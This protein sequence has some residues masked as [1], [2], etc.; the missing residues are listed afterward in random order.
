MSFQNH[1]AHPFTPFANLG[2]NRLLKMWI[3]LRLRRDGME[4]EQGRWCRIYRR[5]EYCYTEY[6]EDNN[7]FWPQ[8]NYR[9]FATVVLPSSRPTVQSRSRWC[10][11]T[12][13]ACWFNG[14]RLGYLEGMLCDRSQCARWQSVG[15]L[16]NCESLRVRI[17][18][19]PDAENVNIL[20]GLCLAEL[21]EEVRCIG[22]I[23]V[24]HS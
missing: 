19:R 10:P 4:T 21:E 20:E 11:S 15:F 24:L 12:Q 2:G 18:T 3:S 23:S 7:C 16:R 17:T 8:Q 22:L 14:S 13:F 1:R 5:P 6:I 9:E